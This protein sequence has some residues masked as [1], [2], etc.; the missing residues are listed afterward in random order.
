MGTRHPQ[1]PAE[2]S[3][4]NSTPTASPHFCLHTHG[5]LLALEETT[6]HH[7]STEWDSQHWMLW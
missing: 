5:H 4:Q 3:Q 2:L 7:Q 6:A 1:P